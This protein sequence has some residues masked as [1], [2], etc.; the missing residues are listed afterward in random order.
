METYQP[1]FDAVRSKISNGDIGAAVEAAM[2]NANIS[3]YFSMA[4]NTMQYAAAEHQRPS[5]VFRPKLSIDGNQWC[6]L[7]GDNLQDGV[8]G[9]GDSPSDA[10]FDF[11]R[12]WFS[13]LEAHDG[14]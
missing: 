6:A 5:A 11:D 7:Y 14:K 2:S 8:A 3:H 9:F 10:M 12:A 4:M 1:I 13:K